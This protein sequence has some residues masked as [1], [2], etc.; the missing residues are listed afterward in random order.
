M[1][2]RMSALFALTASALALTIFLAGCQGGTSVGAEEPKAKAAAPAP[3][4]VRVKPAAERTVA[5]T[6]SATGTLA[7]DEQ[8]VL[9]TKVAGRLA[10]IHAYCRRDVIQTYFLFLRLELLRGRITPEQHSAALAATA[11]FRAELD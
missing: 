1:I 3:R 7:A 10:E 8:V 9:G 5:R 6:V 11:S 4:E 2:S